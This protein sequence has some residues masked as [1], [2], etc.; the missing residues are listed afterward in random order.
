MFD[1]FRKI[2]DCF[3]RYDNDTISMKSEEK[4]RPD[5]ELDESLNDFDLSFTP[6]RES[7]LDITNCNQFVIS[8]VNYIESNIGPPSI[9][10]EYSRILN[11][12]FRYSVQDGYS[13]VLAIY[14]MKQNYSSVRQYR[15]KNEDIFVVFLIL[16]A[17]CTLDVPYNNRS[18]F[19]ISG[20]DNLNELELQC[21][22]EM[23]YD[24]S[25]DL[26][27]FLDFSRNFY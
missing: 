6:E 21:L 19:R 15:D 10:G 11:M 12:L 24:I 7:F 17:K 3:Y 8:C 18:Y 5:T 27:E 9:P 13:I 14:Y 22:K 20:I 2:I 4:I 16:A 1:F 26:A 25:F 23:N